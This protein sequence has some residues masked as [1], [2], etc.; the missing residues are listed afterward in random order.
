MPKNS[1][2][3]AM[4]MISK[5]ISIK[6]SIIILVVWVFLTWL[7]SYPLPKGFWSITKLADNV[8]NETVTS[9]TTYILGTTATTIDGKTV[10]ILTNEMGKNNLIRKLK[11]LGVPNRS[12][13]SLEIQFIGIKFNPS[14]W[15]VILLLIGLST[16]LLKKEISLDHN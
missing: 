6:R 15:V 11:D 16:S 7:S 10:F 5:P 2:L 3:R 8:K 12:I 14:F 13:N 9:I 1:K 4:S